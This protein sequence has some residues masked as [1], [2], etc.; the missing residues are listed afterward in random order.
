MGI[1]FKN[2][3]TKWKELRGSSSFHNVMLFLEFV[4]ISALFWLILALN[5]SAQSNFY[6][7]VQ[8]TNVPDTVTFISDIP[9]RFHVSV[10]DKGTN[11]W[12]NGFLRRPTVSINFK[13][14]GDNDVLRFTHNDILASL[15]SVFGTSAQITALSIDSIHL[16][17]TTNKGKRIPVVVDSRVFPASGSTM[18]GDIRSVPS[19]VLVY[20][21]QSVIDTI[22]KVVTERIDLKNVS[23]TT[24]IEVELRKVKGAR[25]LP[26]QVK[27]IVP[28]EPLVKKE[29]MI[30]ITPINVPH[31]ESLLLFPSKVPVEYYVAMSRLG[32][33]DDDSIELVVDYD[34]INSMKTDR[35]HVELARYPE[36]L[37]NLA[38]KTDSV[39][40]TIVKN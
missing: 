28:I 8:I 4:A 30:T 33:D 2:I 12:R 24:E 38:L 10:R 3:K 14:Y 25:I 1:D 21:D 37:L 40:Y 6:V 32:D 23:E 11:L 31:G 20:G 13:E 9:Q 27:V 29:A 35:L 7:K 22:H 34:K 16:D 15:K 26:S 39:E 18:E 17:Y 19:N 36:R 5:D